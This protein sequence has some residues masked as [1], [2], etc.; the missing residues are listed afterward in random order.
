MIW[1]LKKQRR[2]LT[3]SSLPSVHLDHLPPH[4]RYRRISNV[5]LPDITNT[6]LGSPLT[7]PFS[8]VFFHAQS[9]A[10]EA[11]F[12]S[13]TPTIVALTKGCQSAKVVRRITDVPAGCGSSV[14]SDTL[15]VYILVRVRKLYTYIKV[16]ADLLS[17]GSGR[18]GQ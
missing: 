4:T 9:D 15:V 10:D 14:L 3:L 11:V 2:N 7:T 1:Y 18:S 8:A 12:E 5:R 17:P 6:P 13:Q 16:K